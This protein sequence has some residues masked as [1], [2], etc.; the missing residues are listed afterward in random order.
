MRAL[1]ADGH[2]GEHEG[3]ALRKGSIRRLAIVNRGEAAMRCI[4]AVKALVAEGGHDIQ[5]IALY[6]EA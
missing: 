1:A 4:R 6:T 5:A 3:F 2:S